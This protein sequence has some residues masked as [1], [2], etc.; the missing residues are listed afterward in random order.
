MSAAGGVVIATL[1]RPAAAR[2]DSDRG[3]TATGSATAFAAALRGAGE[4]GR[5]LGRELV[6]VSPTGDAA[7]EQAIMADTAANAPAPILPLTVQPTAT[8]VQASVGMPADAPS[9]SAI[10]S[11]ESEDPAGPVAAP[12]MVDA[13]GES[14]AAPLAAPSPGAS[15]IIAA[16]AGART[17]TPAAGSPSPAAAATAVTT[18]TAATA[19]TD[20]SP[21]APLGDAAESRAA[22]PQADV[23]PAP[24][25]SGRRASFG[26]EASAAVPTTGATT[27]RPAPSVDAAMPAEEP[28]TGLPPAAPAALAPTTLV[29]DAVPVPISAP[30]TAAGDRAAVQSPAHAVRGGVADSFAAQLS[31]P[32]VALAQGPTGIQ[33]VTV[34][35]SPEHLGPVSVRAAVSPEGVRIELLAP[36]ETGRE[37]LRQVLGDLRRDL[38]AAGL[39]ATLDVSPRDAGAGTTG[40][41]PA[42]DESAETDPAPVHRETREEPPRLQ[43]RWSPASDLDV[44]A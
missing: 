34:Q 42:R 40:Q 24:A 9:S 44:I 41:P 20:G 25:D 14:A 39:T 22:G 33:H 43:L 36:G 12:T 26:A 19:V 17:A 8:P 5:E 7:S 13:L 4:T 32:V 28:R 18:A 3:T 10:A 15:S 27:T 2:S 35:V 29:D 37:A 11:S 31:K 16:A 38:V 6:E 1:P 21:R 30:I 23:D